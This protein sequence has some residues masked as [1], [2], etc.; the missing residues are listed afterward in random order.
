MSRSIARFLSGRVQL[1]VRVRFLRYYR[2][3]SVVLQIPAYKTTAPLR[4]YFSEIEKNKGRPSP[5]P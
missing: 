2:R 5:L 4:V 3:Q 1:E